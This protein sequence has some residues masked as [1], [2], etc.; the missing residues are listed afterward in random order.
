MF[1]NLK[2]YSQ[3][4]IERTS[5]MD[6]DCLLSS[7]RLILENY[8]EL[9]V[10]TQRQRCLVWKSA[11]VSSAKKFCFIGILIVVPFFGTVYSKF[12]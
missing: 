7:L 3:V 11:V 9:L 10:L 2:L 1:F 12:I 6:K 5:L 8:F 4:V